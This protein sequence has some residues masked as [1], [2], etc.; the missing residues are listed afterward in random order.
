MGLPGLVLSKICEENVNA[1][2]NLITREYWPGLLLK[3]KMFERGSGS[4]TINVKNFPD[5]YEEIAK[6]MGYEAIG[7]RSRIHCLKDDF[8]A[9]GKQDIFIKPDGEVVIKNIVSE[10][11]CTTVGKTGGKQCCGDRWCRDGHLCCVLTQSPS[12]DLELTQTWAWS[13]PSV[14]SCQM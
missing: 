11:A 6:D 14:M 1:H 3:P 8:G 7:D 13:P 4:W 9:D 2:C 12:S 10:I 5:E